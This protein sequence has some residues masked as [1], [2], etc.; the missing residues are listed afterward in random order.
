MHAVA[1]ELA[2]PHALPAALA[3][4]LEDTPDRLEDRPRLIAPGLTVPGLIAPGLTAPGLTTR[5]TAGY[6]IPAVRAAEF[7]VEPVRGG[8]EHGEFVEQAA[9]PVAFG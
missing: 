6:G 7:G 3:G 8:G 2:D 4:R 5:R 9:D 1:R